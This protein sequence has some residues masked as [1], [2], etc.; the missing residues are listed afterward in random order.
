MAAVTD[1]VLSWLCRG[2]NS[3]TTNFSIILHPEE[4]RTPNTC[5]TDIVLFSIN[6]VFCILTSL[7][8][9]FVRLCNISRTTDH[10][11]IIRYPGHVIRWLLYILYILICLTMLGEGILTSHQHHFGAPPIMYISPLAA[12]LASI[13]VMLYYHYMEYWDLPGMWPLQLLYWVSLLIVECFR[14]FDFY[15][16]DITSRDMIW[17]V[18]KSMIAVDG[19]M[20][21][22]EIYLLIKKGFSLVSSNQIHS[23]L[24]ERKYLH[25]D[26]SLPSALL[27]S[28][29]NGMFKKGM[30]EAIE[31]D[32]MGSLPEEHSA[33]Y[34]SERFA[35]ILLQEKERARKKGR[36]ISFNRALFHFL[37]KG[38]YVS[39]I[40]KFVGDSSGFATPYLISGI[41]TWA[42]LHG[43]DSGETGQTYQ[44]TESYYITVGDFFSNGFVLVI[45]LFFQLVFQKICTQLSY[46]YVIL[47]GAKARAAIQSAVYSKTLRLSTSGIGSGSLTQGQI[48]N[49]MSVDPRSIFLA[50]QWI[51]SIWSI[52]YQVIVFVIILYYQLGF[53]A[54]VSCLVLPLSIPI[55]IYIANRQTFYQKGAMIQSDERLKQ[56]N[57]VLQGMKVVKLNAWEKIFQKAIEI[58]RRKEVKKLRIQM[59]WRVQLNTL[60]NA[61]P[62][63]LM[64]FALSLYSVFSGKS[65]TPDVAFTSLSVINQLQLPLQLLPRVSAFFVIAVVSMRRLGK[66]FKA[67][68]IEGNLLTGKGMNGDTVDE[69]YKEVSDSS[70]LIKKLKKGNVKEYGATHYT[71]L[72]NGHSESDAEAIPMMSINGDT[73]PANIALKVTN[74]SFSW[75]GETRTPIISDVNIDI[76]AGKL[77]MI[78]GKIG[79]GKSSLLSAMLDEMITLNGDVKQRSK[80][81]GVAYAAQTAWLIN[82]SLK[83][84]ILF[85]KPFNY[86]RYKRILHA[87]CLQPDIDILPMGD[88]TE[89]GEKGINLSGGQ[90][91]RISVARAMYSS[92]DVVILDDPLSALDVHVG[93]HMFFKGILDFLIEEGRT[94]VLVTHQV[95]YLDHA[96]QVIYLQDGYVCRRGTMREIEQ[97]DPSLVQSWNVTL[98]TDNEIE[99]AVGYCS[100]TDEEREV[101]KKRVSKSKK[102]E[103]N[104][105]EVIDESSSTL[106]GLEERNRGSVSI[107]YY[108]YYL[109][110]FGLC[111]GFLVCLFAILQNAA[112]AGTQFWL[113]A[114][115][116]AGAELPVNAT[117]EES[118][119]VLKK[120]VGIYCVLNGSDILL[121][122]VWTTILLIQ[123]VH[124]SKTLHNLMLTRILRAPMRFF[125]TTPLG[126]IMNRFASDMQ[127]LDQTQGPFILGLFKFLLS[128]LAGVV[129]NAII[130]WYFIVA[131]I[132]ITLAYMILMKVFIDTSREMQRLVS[133]SN[134]PVF[135]HF[136]ETL[137]GLT[138]IRA[139]RLQKRFKKNIIGKIE[140]NHVSF[141]FL[142]DSN[143][144]LGI[145]LD[146]TGCMMVLAAG[147]TSLAASSLHPA[148][149]GASLVGLAITYACKAAYSLTWVVRNA[150]SVEMGMNSVERIEY[151]TKVDN[152]KYRGSITPKPSWP[153]KGHV[154]YNR[155]YARYAA[156]LPAVLQGVNIDFKPGMKVG[157][158]GRTGSGKSSLTLTLFRIIDT[159]KGVIKIDGVDISKLSL[160]DLRG[161]LAIIPQDPVMFTGTVRFN[162]D[163]EK[164][165]TD[166][167]I[168]DALEIAQLKK[169]VSDLPNS[170]DSM[171]YEG[172]DNF[173]VGE[174]QLFCLARA[175]LK[176]SRILIMDEATASIDVHTDAILQEVVATAFKEETVIT[177]AHRVSTI[178]DSDQIVVLSEGHVAELGTPESLLAKEDSI[179]ASL[180]R[181]KS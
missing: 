156:N 103:Q 152:E 160:T 138:T 100:S 162:L 122:T 116:S 78:V 46:H 68:E 74:G 176:K 17:V 114:W 39:G 149:F 102:G 83:D 7:V 5:S 128:T 105:I 168:W 30:H 28:W 115:S 47:E 45:A 129:V 57:E 120:Y 69:E 125:D 121:G 113:S 109:C 141:C 143:R 49:H 172:G 171:V 66:F 75:S 76:P 1:K 64:L 131:M 8:F 65:L 123:C 164:R 181:A 159:F 44:M 92:Y 166:T 96:D 40:L 139:Y 89:I 86:K 151:Y 36:E 22:I 56:T 157:I 11:Y 3:S 73:L 136:S 54:L 132:P 33:K 35:K 154:T 79:A 130:S 63:L 144:W 140:R 88:L 19:T 124:A 175:M 145:R 147:L 84:N 27:Y 42:T 32:D 26:C 94:V 126:R 178:L 67:P 13:F 153:D 31:I 10:D 23:E 41:I 99:T 80:K 90:K 2:G 101:L 104:D 95:Q 20:C 137:G 61:V 146:L 14:A 169:L 53:S 16:D 167:E 163:P 55:Q 148:T 4:H 51:H 173:S 70:A 133:I 12:L 170:L 24:K 60:A 58:T 97:D 108:W 9:F 21:L 50:L 161:R 111:Q 158:C 77:T 72:T 110:K 43:K 106:I 52:P 180:V 6:L 117:V 107:W 177:I 25:D 112:T 38:L 34:S 87:C 174:K 119:A 142:Q 127:K 93:S 18:N 71:R 48:A 85:G 165:R 62:L 81:I 15:R 150:T 118:N 134:S 155:V 98:K 179:F 59:L 37:K 82:A 135:S 29:M 91:Q